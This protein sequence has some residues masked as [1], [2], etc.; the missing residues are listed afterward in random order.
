MLQKPPV[1][2]VLCALGGAMTQAIV[3]VTLRKLHAVDHLAA[4]HCFF[5]FGTITSIL[6]ILFVGVVSLSAKTLILRLLYVQ[7][8]LCLHIQTGRQSSDESEVLV[9]GIW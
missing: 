1:F 5:A 8:D 7:S 3:Y 4:I 2:A 9:L 6:T